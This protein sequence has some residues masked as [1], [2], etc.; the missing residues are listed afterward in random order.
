MLRRRLNEHAIGGTAESAKGWGGVLSP[1]S[2]ERISRVAEV[3]KRRQ[4]KGDS[5]SAGQSEPAGDRPGIWE[6]TG[7]DRINRRGELSGVTPHPRG[8]RVARQR[9]ALPGSQRYE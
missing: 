5:Q 3:Q 2:V 9:Q 1:R 6:R 8:D 7:M 4:K